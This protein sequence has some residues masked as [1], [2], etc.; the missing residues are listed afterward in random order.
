MS[1]VDKL[2]ELFTRFPGIGPRQARRFV[3]FLLRQ[4]A[5]YRNTLTRAIQDIAANIRQCSLCLR[6]AQLQA[7]EPICDI[8]ANSGR[9][10]SELMIVEKDT[11][12][13]QMEKSGA[14][15]GQY[16]VLG[17]TLSL[18]GKKSFI[19][20]KELASYLK[21]HGD[22]LEEIILALSATPDGEYT[23]EHLALK[24]EEGTSIKNAKVTVLGRGLSTGSELE[25]ADTRTLE[26]ALKN[27][28]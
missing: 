14:Y 19:R 5:G 3:F 4:D 17:D 26:H 13:E 16:F 28:A 12:V 11:D 25:Y 20:E 22:E 15:S 9:S 1:E 21:K 7:K 27:R 24:L 10:K 8:C 6:Y 2:T 18:T 23:T